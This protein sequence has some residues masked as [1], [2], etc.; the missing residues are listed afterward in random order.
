MK[1]LNL[2]TY[3]F[4]ITGKEGSEMILDPVRRKYVKL[5]PEEWVR[6]NFVRYLVNEG[7]YPVGLLGIEVMFRFNKLK[8]RVDIL[9]HNRSGEPVMIVE[10]KSTDIKIDEKVFEQIATYNMK[11]KVPYLVVTNGLH[12]YACKID[13]QEMKFEYLLVIPLYEDLLA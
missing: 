12:H 13:H 10:C 5:T 3:S 2:P 7:K 6:Q 8:R 1:Q 9:V 11:Y 4:K